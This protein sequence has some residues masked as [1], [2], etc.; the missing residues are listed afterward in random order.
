[1]RAL[2]PAGN[3]W[4]DLIGYSRAV[5]S[6]NLIF[7]SGTTAAGADGRALHPGDAGAQTAVILGR[8]EAALLKLGADLKHVVE[9]RIY[10]CDMDQ[11]EAVG[12]AHG[13]VF[14]TIRPAA[15]MIEVNRLIA[16]DLVVEISATAV[17]DSDGLAA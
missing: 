15:T 12:R 11:W 6:G 17:L 10:V 4:G 9:T 5:R 13:K 8:I 14:G 7:V 1:M 16:P 3:P 2:V